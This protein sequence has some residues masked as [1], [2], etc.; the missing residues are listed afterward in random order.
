[1]S[2]GDAKNV[3]PVVGKSRSPKAARV[4]N[5][6]VEL[7]T[8]FQ[9]PHHMEMYYKYDA[10]GL[11]C[12]PK[13]RSMDWRYAM[14]QIFWEGQICLP[15]CSQPIK[16]AGESWEHIM[17]MIPCRDGPTNS[18]W[19]RRTITLKVACF[20]WWMKVLF[21]DFFGGGGHFLRK[22]IPC[23]FLRLQMLATFKVMVLR[24]QE[25]LVGRP[26]HRIIRVM[27]SHDSPDDFRAFEQL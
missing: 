1:M 7:G 18:C 6:F 2:V 27:C 4:T 11:F 20:C 14:G 16:N 13:R 8:F 3:I 22:N 15:S 26:Q 9:T 24:R 10:L 12:S 5:L 23:T 17:R 19:R 25:E 21:W